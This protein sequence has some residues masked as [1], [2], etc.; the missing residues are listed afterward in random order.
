ME[1]VIC[2]GERV[3]VACP[4]PP[5]HT[6]GSGRGEV[7]G[8]NGEPSPTGKRTEVAFEKEIEF[9][10]GFA[11]FSNWKREKTIGDKVARFRGSER[12]QAERASRCTRIPNG[13][14]VLVDPDRERWPCGG[15]AFCRRCKALCYD[16]LASLPRSARSA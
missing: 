5:P 7:Y 1:Y 14:I 15:S 2:A 11:L 12:G 9:E 10:R 16:A 8:P 4:G 3:Q 6:G 13:E